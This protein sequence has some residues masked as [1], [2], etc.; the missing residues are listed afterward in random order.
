V[1]RGQRALENL[2]TGISYLDGFRGTRVLI[3]GHT[4]FKGAWLATWLKD[5]GA[6]VTGFALP[7]EDGRPNLFSDA[8]VA[9]GMTSIMADLRDIDAVARAFEQARPEIVFHLAAQ[10]LVRRSYQEPLETFATNLM[11]TV[12][13]LEA[14]RRAPGLKAAVVI[15][16]DKCYQNDE[17]A[18]DFREDDPLG[19]SDPYSASK[20][21]AELATR[22]YRQSFFSDPDGPLV[23]TTRAGNVIGGG[24][25]AED[26]LVPD[27]ARGIATQ[28]PVVIRNPDS[29]RP[30]QHV[31]EPLRGYL[32]LGA[33]LMEG[34]RAFAEAWNFGPNPE[35]IVPVK[36]IAAR[37]I[38]AWG[39]GSIKNRPDPGAPPEAV[40]LYLNIEKAGE[41]L[42]YKPVLGLEDGI[43]LTVD[44][45]RA[46]RDD[47][48]KA[49][50]LTHQQVKDYWERLR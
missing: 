33:R 24:D 30:W 50:E 25:W 38:E 49:R 1:G 48:S 12:H 20:G 3:T 28:Q 14:C 47:P 46:Y 19:G 44:W 34:E 37:V 17:Q 23:A 45:Y 29:V 31:L 32:M 27:I 6:Q 5:L 7:P 26:R 39:E 11:G 10:S 2:V 40:L 18:E 13:V 35:D 15:T 4:G 41:R 22:A 42:D 16:S 43:G 21:C 9:D 36:E 8:A